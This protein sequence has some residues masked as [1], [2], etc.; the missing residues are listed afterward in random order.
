MNRTRS[1]LW[2]VCLASALAGAAASETSPA[3]ERLD[4]QDAHSVIEASEGLVFVDVFA[5][6]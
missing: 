4:A 6:W 2:V 3:L 1:I 5:N